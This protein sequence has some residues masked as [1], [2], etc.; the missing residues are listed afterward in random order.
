M[1]DGVLTGIGEGVHAWVQ[2]DGTW[3]IN[4]AG[5]VCDGDE[6]ALI[7]TC[8]TRKRTERF[9]A[10]V[11]EVAGPAPIRFAV[12]THLHGDHCYGN[13]LLPA[14]TAIAGHAKTREGLLADVL[15]TAAPPVWSPMPDF[16]VD[17]VRPP[18]VIVDSSLTLYVGERRVELV[19][20]GYAAHTEGDVVAWLPDSG[21]LFAGDLLFHGITP[22]ILMGSLAGA[23]R[24]L[25]WLADFGAATVVPGHGPVIHDLAPVLDAHE[26][27]YRFI[28][29]TAVAGRA[30][31]RSPLAAATDA[32]LGEFADWPD[33][34]RVV[35]NLHRAYADLDG[36][37]VDLVAALTDAITW[38]GGPLHCAV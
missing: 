37:P 13:A 7:D 26:R 28:E 19:H 36:R 16:G 29:A 8:A 32:D 35:L 9:L 24:S 14:E 4:N 38:N 31:G 10:A 2:P 30:A 33:P 1:G 22:M 17:T 18:T 21:V 27:Y 12:N 3:W 5:M 34:E 6:V 11:R 20:P 15:L 23:L 25:R